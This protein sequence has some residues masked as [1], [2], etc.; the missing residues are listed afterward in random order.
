[1]VRVDVNQADVLRTVTE[2]LRR[3]L[4]LNERTCYEVTEPLAPPAIPKGGD[5]F[6]T[7]CAGDGEFPEEMQVGG[8]EDQCTEL[9][10]LVVTGYT[11]LKL[12]QTDHETQLLHHDHRGLLEIKRRILKAL[13]GVDAIDPES[14]ATFLRQVITA[15]HSSRPA[16]DQKNQ[17]GFI[18]LSFRV[19]WDWDLS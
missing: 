6:V 17:L 19:S 14:G 2:H 9:I 5:F 12:D 13:V 1:M 3:A 8:A 11:R 10:E 7:V 18:S 4:D 15:A 16:Y